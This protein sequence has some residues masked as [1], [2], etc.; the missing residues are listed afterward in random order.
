MFMEV[1]DEK[2]V[3]KIMDL[4]ESIPERMC[5]GAQPRF[6]FDLSSKLKDKGEIVEIG[7]CA[8]K[9]LIALASAQKLKENGRKIF[10]IDIQEHKSLR[11]NLKNAGLE[12]WVNLITGHSS[13][14]AKNWSK[15]IE[16]L[17]I[18][19]NHNY[20]ATKIIIKRWSN[21]VL[22]GG[23]I[24]LHDYSFEFAG[25]IKA[26]RET[27]LLYPHVWKVISDRE[28]GSIFVAKRLK[29]QKMPIEPATIRHKLGLFRDEVRAN[30]R[31]VAEDM[32][33]YY[34]NS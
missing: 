4:I 10:S 16:L 1:P 22:E 32:R 24:A 31:A 12:N 19:A 25:V 34:F 8:G 23:Y 30:V 9:S 18:D 3:L 20:L 28:T 7:T 13:K 27:I 14:I 17:W 29:G 2:E 15:P 11:Q 5:G 6:L 21:Y 33:N 26:V